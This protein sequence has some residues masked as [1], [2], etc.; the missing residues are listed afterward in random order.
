MARDAKHFVSFGETFVSF[1]LV[2]GLGR[3]QNEIETRA[4]RV[5]MVVARSA[6]TRR[7]RSHAALA[8]LYFPLDC[9][10]VARPEGRASFNAL[11]LAM[12]IAFDRLAD[13]FSAT[14]RSFLD[15]SDVPPDPEVEVRK[16]CAEKQLIS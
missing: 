4:L 2:F 16:N 6:A 5:W 12:T 9:F 3:G 7:S 13:C 14:L 1:L 15:A 10:A 8:A 11:W